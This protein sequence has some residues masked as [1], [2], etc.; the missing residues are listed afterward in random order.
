MKEDY[1]NSIIF[2]SVYLSEEAKTKGK[3]APQKYRV[4]LAKVH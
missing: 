1:Q 4:N 3:S 2:R